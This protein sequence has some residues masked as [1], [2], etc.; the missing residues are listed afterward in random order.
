MQLPA[1]VTKKAAGAGALPCNIR[2][3]ATLRYDRAR[4]AASVAASLLF[5]LQL[6]FMFS[7]LSFNFTSPFVLYLARFHCFFNLPGCLHAF[8]FIVF[9]PL[10]IYISIRPFISY[11]SSF[12][13]RHAH[14]HTHTTYIR[15]G[16][17]YDSLRVRLGGRSPQR[18]N[19]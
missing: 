6:V 8:V 4:A 11:A 16:H 19:I 10:F 13:S 17:V 1:P 12:F 3:L 2:G 5:L 14:T 18:V 15:Y 7:Y 9:F